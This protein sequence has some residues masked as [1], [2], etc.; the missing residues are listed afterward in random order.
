[1]TE[2][3]GHPDHTMRRAERAGE[4]RQETRVHEDQQA[5]RGKS[6]LSG[7]SK[8]HLPSEAEPSRHSRTTGGGFLRDEREQL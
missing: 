3:K 4:R 2:V 1:M 7:L 8:L 5:A 6:L